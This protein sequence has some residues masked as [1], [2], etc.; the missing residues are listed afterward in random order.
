VFGDGSQTRSFCYVDDLVDG[1][2]RLMGTAD[3]VTGPINIGNPGE[4]TMLELA[5]K[6]VDLVGSESTVAYRPL[7][8]DDPVRRRPNI[9]LARKLLDW[10]PTVPLDEGLSRTVAY[11][12]DLLG[13]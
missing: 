11:F 4:F 10:S 12:R 5:T 8:S 9:D 1:L 13:A 7:P 6:V 3:D 2:I